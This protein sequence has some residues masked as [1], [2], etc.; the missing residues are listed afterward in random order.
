V[1]SVLAE[2]DDERVEQTLSYER[3]HKNRAEVIKIAERER[4]H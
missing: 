4:T 1:Q 2:A 3:S